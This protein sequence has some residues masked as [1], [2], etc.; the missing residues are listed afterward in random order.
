MATDELANRIRSALGTIRR[1][2]ECTETPMLL[3]ERGPRSA[4]T[5]LPSSTIVLRADVQI[6]LGFWCGAILTKWPFLLDWQEWEGEKVVTRRG[7]LDCTDV[8]AMANFLDK[9]VDRVA[10]W[11]S[12]G[13]TILE[14]VSPLA[15]AVRYVARPP[16]RDKVTIGECGHCHERVMVP[17]RTKV[18]VPSTD[19][20]MEPLWTTVPTALT[21]TMVIRHKCGI[22]YSLEEWYKHIVGAQRRLTA[23]DLVVE[24]HKRLGV[25]YSPTTV[26]VWAKRGIIS[27]KGYS[28]KGAALYDL[29]E[30][31]QELLTKGVVAA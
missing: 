14:E 15:N 25:R 27:N 17:L 1:Y 9:H 22:A 5:S 3:G 29:R 6:T 20:D 16:K 18:P 31:I 4:G 7:S 12:Y 23:N 21:P 8:Y 26:R 19:P 30:V 2:W 24:L 28:A 13:E 11:E 10:E